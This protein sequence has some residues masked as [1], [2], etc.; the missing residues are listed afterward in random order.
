MK[1]E[2]E[3][4]LSQDESKVLEIMYD[5]KIEYKKGFFKSELSRDTLA[6][7]SGYSV[8][9]VKR[10]INKLIESSYLERLG[11]KRGQYIITEKAILA[12]KI[13]K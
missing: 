13:L 4:E 5:Y 12:I 6:E 7:L 8:W 9:Q 11:N 2:F 3:Q 1:I 10:Q